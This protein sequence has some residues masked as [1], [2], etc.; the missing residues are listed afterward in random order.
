MAGLIALF[1][2]LASGEVLL[3]V[4]IDDNLRGQTERVVFPAAVAGLAVSVCLIAGLLVA[5]AMRKHH[6]P[7][8]A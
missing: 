7:S 2:A 6:A 3:R 5:A 1:V 4:A 8:R